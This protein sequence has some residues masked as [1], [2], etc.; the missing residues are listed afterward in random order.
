MNIEQYAAQQQPTPQEMRTAP[1]AQEQLDPL[2]AQIAAGKYHSLQAD[3]QE[4]LDR[5]A[6]PDIMLTVLVNGLFGEGSPQAA[7]AEKLIDRDVYWAGYEPIAEM[8]KLW[9]EYLKGQREKIKK[10]DTMLDEE[11]GKI[12]EIRGRFENEQISKT[13]GGLMKILAFRNRCTDLD[14]QVFLHR[15]EL[16]Y[17]QFHTD[18]EAMGLLYGTIRAHRDY[19]DTNLDLIQRQA[20]E[21]LQQKIAG[22]LLGTD[23]GDGATGGDL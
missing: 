18:P 2:G 6:S 1:Q 3:M 13:Y 15:L 7:A 12:A 11:M 16:L 5:G 10:Y 23:T 20:V 14:P 19:I 9:H 21:E 17:K 8:L 22:A 4:S